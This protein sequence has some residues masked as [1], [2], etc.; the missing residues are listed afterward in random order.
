MKFRTGLAVFLGLVA[1]LL[2]VVRFAGDRP[3]PPVVISSPP[4]PAEMPAP[5]P[6]EA[7]PA[8]EVPA[9]QLPALS[10]VKVAE[11]PIHAVPQEAAAPTGGQAVDLPA[12]SAG[13]SDEVKFGPRPVT[14]APPARQFGGT[15]TVA[16]PVGLKIEATEISLFGIKRAGEGDRCGEA[17]GDCAT[18][19]RQ[20]L[21]AR[22]GAAG[23]VSCRIPAPRPGPA[24]AICLDA[25]GVD[26]SGFLIA[27]GLAL[28]DT[29]Q[30][31]DYV[32]AEGIARNL[33]RGLWKFR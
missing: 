16:G 15:A 7:S 1:L 8:A 6:T 28:A 13:Q 18:A 20:A 9:A 32:G 21:A 5:P 30:S 17:A 11:R 12:R 10:E 33:K 4:A 2:L 23:Q 14:A 31:Y 26:L 24:Y 22:V 3:P 25:G 29:G 19:A 27:Q